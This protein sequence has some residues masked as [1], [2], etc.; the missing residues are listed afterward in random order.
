MILLDLMF[1][2][3]VVVVLIQVVFYIVFFRKF[4][5][6]KQKKE[7]SKNISISVIICAKNEAE[8]L[9]NFLPSI[10]NQDYPSF[11]VVLINDASQD[12]TLDVMKEFAAKN[13]SIKIV[14]VKNIE[15]FWGNKKYAIT[16]GIKASL[17]DF[18]LFTDAD[19]KPVSKHWIKE[20]SSHFSNTK[21]IVLGY[22][23]Y[24]KVKKS[25]LNKLI[26]FETLLTAIQYFSFANIGLPFMGVGRNLAYRKDVFFNANGFMNHMDVRSG[27]DDLFVNQVATAKN[28]SISFSKKSFTTSLPKTTF[29]TWF[30]Q[31][32]RHVSTAKHYK[33]KHKMLLALFYITQF[34]FWLLAITLLVVLFKWKIVLAL[35][36][37]RLTIQFIVYGFSAKKLGEID[38]IALL[39]FLELFL[40]VVQLTIFISNLVSKPKRWR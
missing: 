6:V 11:E 35:L 21:T 10:L 36:I 27:D 14:N 13:N 5:F 7:R 34:L 18:L 16:L 19:C 20:M 30:R 29:S 2:T 23:A 26:R 33:L 12:T 4:A 15:A 38:V 22:G 32:K 8:N 3:F 37:V 39:P 31:K 24:T 1:Y 25:L 28:T 17:Y 40:I 9:Q